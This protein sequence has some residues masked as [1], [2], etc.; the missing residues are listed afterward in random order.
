M[1][2]MLGKLSEK[3]YWIITRLS[4][5]CP[6][7]P[8]GRVAVSPGKNF[9]RKID[10]KKIGDVFIFLSSIFLLVSEFAAVLSLRL[11][12]VRLWHQFQRSK[13]E[14]SFTLAS[15]DFGNGDLPD[16]GAEFR[17]GSVRVASGREGI[18]LC[19]PELDFQFIQTAAKTVG[20][21]RQ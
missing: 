11:G 15:L 18:G 21:L 5:F 2:L 1:V 17:F 13:V 14:W 6:F 3:C 19:V 9:G 16:E 8:F 10:G 12:L 7:G 4:S 20:N